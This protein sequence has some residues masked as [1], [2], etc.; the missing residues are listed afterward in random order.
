MSDQSMLKGDWD[1]N[2]KLGYKYVPQQYKGLL[3]Y[4]T[5]KSFI[6]DHV[7]RPQPSGKG[8]ASAESVWGPGRTCQISVVESG[9]INLSSF[10]RGAEEG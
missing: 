6:N 9:Q 10:P 5:R 8:T 7:L 4:G 3:V 1:I 2:R